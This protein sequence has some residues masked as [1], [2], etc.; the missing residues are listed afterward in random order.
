MLYIIPDRFAEL[1]ASGNMTR[2]LRPCGKRRHAQK[3]DT[4]QLYTG[5]RSKGRRKLLSPDPVCT[6][7]F[8]VSVAR[9]GKKL[10]ISMTGEGVLTEPPLK[11]QE[12]TGSPEGE[13]KSPQE[14]I[15]WCEAKHGLP[16]EGVLIRW[17]NRLR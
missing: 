9:Q 11:I 16:F 12:L 15:A 17:E 8:Y 13:F 6:G 5:A 10:K 14:L 4:L 7:V 1:V 3:G 2:T